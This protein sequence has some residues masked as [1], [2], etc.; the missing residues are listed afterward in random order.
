MYLYSLKQESI[1]LCYAVIFLFYL[2]F[3][4]EQLAKLYLIANS[5]CLMLKLHILSSVSKF[6]LIMTNLE[7]GDWRGRG[8]G[9]L[10]TDFL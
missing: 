2:C 1:D 7:L 8:G 10:A 3:Y 6:S 5:I 9:N 4:K